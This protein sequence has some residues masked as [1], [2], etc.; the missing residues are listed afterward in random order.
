MVSK[1]SY[2]AGVNNGSITV[3]STKTA[4]RKMGCHLSAKNVKAD[5]PNE[6]VPENICGMK[7]VTGPL[8]ALSKSYAP[9]AANGKQRVSFQRIDQK[10]M[11]SIAGA[12]NVLT[13]QPAKLTI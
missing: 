12:R 7:N 5:V 10:M 9:S 4:W 6:K 11:V 3:N 13:K 1:K 2:A 8:K